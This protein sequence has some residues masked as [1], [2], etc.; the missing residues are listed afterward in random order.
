L[1]LP[2]PGAGAAQGEG[3]DE[4]TDAP[5]A[6]FS[7]LAE[8]LEAMRDLGDV[9]ILRT[10]LL[11][12]P[13]GDGARDEATDQIWI[14]EVLNPDGEVEFLVLD[15][16]T[17]DERRLSANVLSAL[18]ERMEP[19]SDKIEEKPLFPIHMVVRGSTLPD[20]VEGSWTDDILTGGPGPDVFV[21]TPGEDIIIDFDP[22]EDFLDVTD[23]A[24]GEYGLSLL[25]DFGQLERY[26]YEEEDI[27]AR[28]A[29]VL[30]LDG[31][32]GD[33]MTAFLG[34]DPDA[35]DPGRIAFRPGDDEAWDQDFTHQP[36][37]LVVMSDGSVM[38]IPDH[39]IE[40]PFPGVDLIFGEDIAVDALYEDFDLPAPG[41]R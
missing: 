8:R 24:N 26:T 25:T 20:S 14:V 19:G 36:D 10:E 4:G 30:D 28:P 7:Q 3:E 9:T 23:M 34:V 41:E 33:W 22:R 27:F 38:I 17:L 5:V 6:S 32:A 39:G 18:L 29:V 37:R 16:Q 35:V 12:L 11:G 40:E 1:W 21:L 15:G 13:A 31:Q 2:G